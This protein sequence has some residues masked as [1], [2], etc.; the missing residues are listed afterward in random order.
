MP[1]SSRYAGS[2]GMRSGLVLLRL[3]IMDYLDVV[4]LKVLIVRLVSIWCKLMECMEELATEPDDQED[5]DQ[6]QVQYVRQYGINTT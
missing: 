5:P 4:L 2:G 1:Y 3:V 6:G